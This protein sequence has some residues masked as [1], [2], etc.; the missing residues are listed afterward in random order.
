MKLCEVPTVNSKSWV[1]SCKFG[2][3]YNTLRC[4]SP[5]KKFQFV[6]C[7]TNLSAFMSEVRCVCFS[8]WSVSSYP[9]AA[10][11]TSPS[12]L[13]VLKNITSRQYTCTFLQIQ[14]TVTNIGFFFY[15]KSPDSLKKTLNFE[16][17]CLRRQLINSLKPYLIQNLMYLGVLVN[18]VN[19]HEDI[20]FSV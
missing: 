4:C 11:C 10:V 7:C 13:H 16:T 12:T 5:C 14:S 17:C 18:S 20:F 3:E 1:P 15:C 2:I 6:H 8:G 19:I 9:P